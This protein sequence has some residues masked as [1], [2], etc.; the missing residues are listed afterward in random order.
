LRARLAA[1]IPA[2]CGLCEA[3]SLHSLGLEILRANGGAI[4]LTSDFSIAEAAR[5][6]AMLASELQIGRSKAESLLRTISLIK[7]TGGEA[8]GETSAALAAYRRLAREG[9]FVDF[10]DLIALAVELFEAHS[11]ITAGWRQ[12][13][14]HIC[15]D[16]FQDVDQ[17][18]YRLLR[19]LTPP[20]GNICVIGDPDQAIYGFRGASAD[21][22]CRFVEDFPAAQVLRLGRNYRST[23]T[24]V[25][26]SAAVIG[27]KA[28]FETTRPRGS[29]VAHYVAA[30]EREEA[31]FIADEIE[32]L[33]GGHDLLTANRGATE[34][35][36][37]SF[38]DFA[39]LYRTDAQSTALR[40][41]FD[42]AGIPFKKSSPQ[43]IA[44]DPAV[45]AILRVLP[46]QKAA[47]DL[48]S[49]IEAAAAAAQG[50][51]EELDATNLAQARWR[52]LA[53]AASVSDERRLLEEVALATE[54]D[55]WDERADRVSLLTMHAAKGLEF[56]VVFIAG[57]EDGLTPFSFRAFGETA[58]SQAAPSEEEGEERRL[59]YVAMT[60]AK[61][62]LVLTRAERR[63]WRG[64]IRSREASR[65]LARIPEGLVDRPRLAGRAPRAKVRQY[66]LF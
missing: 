31:T 46:G 63:Y 48:A 64:E 41:A 19:L 53:L 57:L 29:P 60:R 47:G 39:V 33:I 11:D 13:F 43:P 36:P 55:F 51:G 52:L 38:A 45:N 6:A 35:R 3:H 25:A 16:E 1:L 32:R 4:G 34:A 7:R 66:S 9:N 22:F 24:I 65:Y 40:E 15:V 26:A 59:F 49:R 17:Q 23:G 14:R 62:L 44:G 12:R 21:C 10:D 18:Q 56:A 54:A 2:S 8:K 50:I 61:D 37:V 20:E 58:N 42:A 28:P 5:R 27:A 30:N